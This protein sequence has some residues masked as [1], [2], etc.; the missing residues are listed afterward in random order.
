MAVLGKRVAAVTVTLILID[1]QLF[2]LNLLVLLLLAV[3]VVAVVA[4]VAAVAR[5]VNNS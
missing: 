2:L 5:Y 1:E 3:G 4:A